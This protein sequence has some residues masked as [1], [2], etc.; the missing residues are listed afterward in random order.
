MDFTTPS[1][2]NTFK[3][4]QINALAG[5][6]VNSHKTARGLQIIRQKQFFLNISSYNKNNNNLKKKNNIDIYSI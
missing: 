1:D 3:V 5:Q 6:P 2:T 4:L